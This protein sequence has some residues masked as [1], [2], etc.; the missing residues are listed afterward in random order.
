MARKI[1]PKLIHPATLRRSLDAYHVDAQF[2][3]ANV[4][5]ALSF[6]TGHDDLDPKKVIEVVAPMLQE[7]ADRMQKWNDGISD[8]SD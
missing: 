3:L 2:L 8:A 7:A 6:M 4:R 5:N 1:E